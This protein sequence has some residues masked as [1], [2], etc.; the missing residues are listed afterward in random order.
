MREHQIRGANRVDVMKDDTGTPT[1]LYTELASWWPLF[2]HPDDYADEASWIAHTFEEVLGEYPA[3]VLELGSGGGNVA[4]YLIRHGPMTLVEPSEEMV[5]VSRQLNPQAEHVV[6]DMR[7]IR[8]GKTF[9]AVLIHDAIMYMT[10]QSDL[11]AALTTAHVHL[12]PGGTLMVLP[13]H[14]AETFEPGDD[15]GGHDARDGSG[16][17][18][19]YVSWTQPIAPG[20][21]T[22]VV[23]YA[24]LLRAQDGSVTVR[25]DRHTEGLF[26]RSVW[27]EAFVRAGFEPPAVRIDPWNREVHIGRASDR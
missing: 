15:S 23:D 24:I 10:T 13:D 25:H 4:S 20:A 21:T 27:R 9:D 3:R 16:R 8:L 6:G 22:F 2:S 11:V 18:L 1:A 19:R 14:V 26:S 7:D 12:A 17:A 5:A